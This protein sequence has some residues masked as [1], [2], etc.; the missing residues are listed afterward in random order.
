[1][2]SSS[3][4]GDFMYIR[5]PEAHIVYKKAETDIWEPYLDVL[6]MHN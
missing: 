5:Q 4:M 3:P 6:F 1:M 2:S